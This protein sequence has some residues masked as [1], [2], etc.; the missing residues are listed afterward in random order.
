MPRPAQTRASI[1]A[2]AHPMLP[3]HRGRQGGFTLVELLVVILT[4]S[5]L[6][7][8]LLPAITESRRRARRAKCLSNLKQLGQG[9]SMFLQ[10]EGKLAA[11]LDVPPWR[12][13]YAMHLRWPNRYSI[14]DADPSIAKRFLYFSGD[15][16]SCR[17]LWCDGM[18]PIYLDQGLGMLHPKYLTT[19]EVF[20][21]P[22]AEIWTPLTGWPAPDLNYYITYHSRE[23]AAEDDDGNVLYGALPLTEKRYERVSYASCA[24][25][26]GYIAHRHSWNV[27]FMDGS[28]AWFTGESE[29]DEIRDLGDKEWFDT[30]GKVEKTGRDSPWM[31]FDGWRQAL[32]ASEE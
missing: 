30:V 5:L 11:L 27:L 10:D 17:P 15:P 20:Y 13:L 28:A 14:H 7:A 18:E 9:M 26:R 8:M 31:H 16:G 29:V 1:H 12:F 6:T 21:C 24:S 3:T 23:G 4:I 19:P 32:P 25:W 2:S 22:E